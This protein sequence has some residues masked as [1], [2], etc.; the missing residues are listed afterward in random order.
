MK[1]LKRFL[2]RWSKAGRGLVPEGPGRNDRKG[3]SLIELFGKFPDDAAAEKWFEEVRWSRRTHCPHCGCYGMITECPNRKPMPYHCGDCRNRFSVRTGTV[4]SHSKVPLQKWVIAIYLHLSSLKGVKQ[5]EAA[6][7]PP[8]NAENGLV[9][10]LRLP[11]LILQYSFWG[12]PVFRHR[13]SPLAKPMPDFRFPV[14]CPF[15]RAI[16]ASIVGFN[17][18]IMVINHNKPEKLV[19]MSTVTYVVGCSLTAWRSRFAGFPT[20]YNSQIFQSRGSSPRLGKYVGPTRTLRGRRTEP[21]QSG[22]AILSTLFGERD[23]LLPPLRSCRSRRFR[24]AKAPGWV[25]RRYGWPSLA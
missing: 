9:H 3:I 25:S 6:P 24:I 18:V 19:V 2:G 23:C 1:I 10:G 20:E 8:R 22:R 16:F 11:S 7:G 5:H 14:L 21:G 15:V 4:L 17:M 12:I 13:L